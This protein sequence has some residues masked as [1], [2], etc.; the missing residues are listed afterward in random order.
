[1]ACHRAP[2]TTATEHGKKTMCTYHRRKYLRDVK[3]GKIQP[4][5]EEV[6]QA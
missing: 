5:P 6:K 2:N 3:L 1:M 4:I